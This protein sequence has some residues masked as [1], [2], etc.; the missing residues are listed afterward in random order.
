MVEACVGQFQTEGVFS[1]NTPSYL[2]GRLAVR[3]P[4]REL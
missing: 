4:L 2:I 3:K 1:V